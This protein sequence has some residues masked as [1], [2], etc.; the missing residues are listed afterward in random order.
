LGPGDIAQAHT[1]GEWIDIGQLKA[2][3]GVYEN[4]IQQLCRAE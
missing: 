4:M 3:V 2:A 1:I